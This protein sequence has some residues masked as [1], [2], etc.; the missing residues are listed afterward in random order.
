MKLILSKEVNRNKA[1]KK[2]EQS[3]EVK[4]KSILDRITL[5]PQ[6]IGISCTWQTLQTQF[7]RFKDD[8]LKELQIS[9]EG[10]NLSGLANEPS[11]FQF[12]MVNMAEELFEQKHSAQHKKDK[13]QQLQAALITHEK[14]SLTTQGVIKDITV[15][16][17]VRHLAQSPCPTNRKVFTP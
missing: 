4:W 12:L 15:E 2:T 10:A 16:M 14:S 17:K 13:K 9:E 3:M 11:E 1:Y 7:N 6:L 5:M 8:V